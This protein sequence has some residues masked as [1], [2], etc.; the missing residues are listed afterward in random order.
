M[1]MRVGQGYDVHQLLAG[2]DLIL[3]GVTIPFEKGLLG[4]SDADALLHAVTD[5]L[6]GAAG[7]GDI[8]SHFPDTAAEFEGADSRVLLRAAYAHVREQGWQVV[9][10]DTT[11]IAQRPKL[12]PF[13]PAM[14]ENLAADLGLQVSAVNV[15][16]KTNE[17]MGYLGRSEAMEA[18]AVVL[19]AKR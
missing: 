15:K 8:G 7:L 6:L 13:I 17:K 1:D 16:G 18:Q 3:G 5:A 4:H 10:V 2:R 9:N 11:I 12:A 19:L 14:R